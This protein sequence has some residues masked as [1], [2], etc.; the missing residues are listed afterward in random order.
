MK[1]LILTLFIANSIC[2]Y[3]Q[4]ELF[5]TWTVGCPI[6]FIDQ[7]SSKHCTI[8]PMVQDSKS[9]ISINDFEMTIDKDEITFKMNSTKTKVKYNWNSDLHTIEFT[10]KEQKYKFKTLYNS[11]ERRYILKDVEGLLITLDQKK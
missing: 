2:S 7:A 8:C 4:K 3:A 1:K 10:L 6:E 5:G 11:G 9:N